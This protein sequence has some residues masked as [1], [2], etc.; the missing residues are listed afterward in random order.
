MERLNAH[1]DR[2]LFK[3]TQ[4]VNSGANSILRLIVHHRRMEGVRLRRKTK[5]RPWWL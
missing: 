5:V 1:R 2:N 4:L 3:V